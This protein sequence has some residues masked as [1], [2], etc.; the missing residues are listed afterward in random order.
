[1][2]DYVLLNKQPVELPEIHLMTLAEFRQRRDMIHSFSSTIVGFDVESSSYDWKDPNFSIRTIGLSNN[3]YTIS[4]DLLGADEGDLE[5]F[6]QWMLTIDFIAFNGVMECGS[7]LAW[8][9]GIGNIAADT[10]IL[11]ADLATEY[12]RPWNLETAMADLLGL[13]KEG[14]AVKDHMKANKWT[15]EDVD[16]FDFEILGRYNAIDAFGAF[17]LYKYFN[18]LI[19]S[20]SETWGQYYW[21]YHKVDCLN[22]VKLQVEARNE[23]IFIETEALESA[24]IETNSNKD[25]ALALFL[26]DEAIRPCIED[27]NKECV[28]EIRAGEPPK[29]TKAGRQTARYGKWVEKVK[30]AEN[31]QHFNTNSTKQ[32][33][34]LFFD[35]M[36][37]Q[38]V[39]FTDTG[40]P[41]TASAALKKMGKYGHMLLDYRKYVTQLKFITQVRESNRD[42]KIYPHIKLW[43]T[44]STRSSSGRVE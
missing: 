6:K 24:Y 39:E 37:L 23:G 19:E 40:K 17:E 13:Q 35:K 25:E 4:I 20:Y 38:P 2:T 1:M 15:W 32:L 21:E 28:A 44:L 43:S 26:G 16:K 8:A 14:D 18:R 10:Y 11:F 22:S 12:R 33:N 29:Y 30:E 3:D 34:W 36:G 27:Y 9:G 7:L 41:S 5:S 42:G 31:T